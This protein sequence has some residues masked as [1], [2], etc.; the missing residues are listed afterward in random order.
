M[1]TRKV[2]KRANRRSGVA[3][4][5]IKSAKQLIDCDEVKSIEWYRSQSYNVCFQDNGL[6][7]LKENS[8]NGKKV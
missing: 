8:K 5:A 2:Q 7:R 3:K 4:G 1:G 6:I